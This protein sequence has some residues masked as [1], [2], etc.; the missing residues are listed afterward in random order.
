MQRYAVLMFAVFLA[1]PLLAGEPK[2]VQEPKQVKISLKLYEGDPRSKNKGASRVLSEPTLIAIAGE[3][4][5]LRSGGTQ[6]LADHPS[7]EMPFG[8]YCEVKATV[9][10][11]KKVLLELMVEHS[12]R[13]ADENDDRIS[14]QGKIVRVAAIV[15]PGEATW[16][17]GNS[18][19][20]SKPLWLS[21]TT[22]IVPA[23]EKQ[24]AK[25]SDTSG[26]KADDTEDFSTYCTSPIPK[27]RYKAGGSAMIS[28]PFGHGS[29]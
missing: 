27:A 16:I 14:V 21:V 8:V 6:M 23:K 7:I 10:K 12:G 2:K 29:K 18:D 5:T 28:G 19:R 9:I 3:P 15:T 11:D 17:G 1:T 26:F 25:T 4:A 24:A 20:E 22:E 13:V